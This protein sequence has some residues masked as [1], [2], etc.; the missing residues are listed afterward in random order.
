[1]TKPSRGARNNMPICNAMEG[2]CLI[3]AQLHARSVMVRTHFCAAQP[4]V[5][6]LGNLRA[7]QRAYQQPMHVFAVA[8]FSHHYLDHNNM[9]Q[10]NFQAS[11]PL[12]LMARWHLPFRTV[13]LLFFW[14]V[15]CKSVEISPRR[16]REPSTPATTAPYSLHVNTPVHIRL[17]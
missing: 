17:T 8:T 6:L 14:Q 1:V 3:L 13:F 16:D 11:R 4:R 7:L 12:R 2:G 15:C 9:F 5:P 10:R